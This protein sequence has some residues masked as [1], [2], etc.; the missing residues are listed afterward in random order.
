MNRAYSDPS[1]YPPVRVLKANPQYAC[2][3]Q[4]DY[5]G[6]VSEFT[7][8]SQYLYHHFFFKKINPELGE[9]LEQVSIVEMYH[10]ELLAETIIALGGNPQIIGS[11]STGG[12]FWNGS[13]IYYGSQLCDQ[14]KADIDAEYKAIEEYYKHI[15][16]IDDPYVK[17]ILQRIIADEQV[18]IRLFNHA[19]IRFCGPPAGHTSPI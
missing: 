2:L 14:L 6:V 7:A 11:F 4:D 15:Q 3:L 5:A 13:F 8:I 9:L 17:A 19:L 1:P 10:M 16:M 18:H 12:N